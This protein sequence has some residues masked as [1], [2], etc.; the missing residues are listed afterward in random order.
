MEARTN[1]TEHRTRGTQPRRPTYRPAASSQASS[2]GYR[3]AIESAR[4]SR[5]RAVQGAQPT[6]QPRPQE[7]ALPVHRS[8]ARAPRGLWS[9]NPHANRQPISARASNRRRW[10]WP[11]LSDGLRKP[12][13]IAAAVAESSP[14][15]TFAAS[16]VCPSRSRRASQCALV[17]A[18][19]GFNLDPLFCCPTWSALA[20]SDRRSPPCLPS[21]GWGRSFAICVEMSC[22]CARITQDNAVFSMDTTDGNGGK[23]P[24]KKCVVKFALFRLPPRST[25]GRSREILQVPLALGCAVTRSHRTFAAR[26]ISLARP[27]T[28]ADI[29]GTGFLYGSRISFS[30]RSRSRRRS[31]RLWRSPRPPVPYAGDRAHGGALPSVTSAASAAC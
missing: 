10:A 3:K 27:M 8:P 18:S 6:W 13:S 9:R 17:F 29:Y 11:L 25:P 30:R 1:S 2:P 15:R 24:H 7:M 23:I 28:P 14:A 19:L 31:W 20:F 26:A 4:C 21:L 16:S 5:R 12:T 22:N